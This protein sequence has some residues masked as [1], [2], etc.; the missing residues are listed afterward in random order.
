MT[1]LIKVTTVCILLLNNILNIKAQL[2]SSIDFDNIELLTTDSQS[3][4]F[5]ESL[6]I[7]YKNDE[8]VAELLPLE[9]HCLYYGFTFTEAYQ[10]YNF[11]KELRLFQTNIADE[12]YQVALEIGKK[13]F[14]KDPF[15]LNLLSGLT[16]CYQAD[17]QVDKAVL[18]QKRYDMILQTILK[19]GDGRSVENAFVVN[20]GSDEKEIL[21]YLQLEVTGQSL[22]GYCEVFVVAQPNEHGIE[23]VYF[24]INKPMK[25]LEALVGE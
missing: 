7:T 1:K 10:P 8:Q 4:L 11:G 12:Q 9:Y 21:K 6:M 24:N 18:W 16:Y 13:L 2:I 5:Y 20:N 22:L 25:K 17:N 19:S 3:N 23:K 14:D 15:N